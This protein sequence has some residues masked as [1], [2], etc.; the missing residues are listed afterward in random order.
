M[1]YFLSTFDVTVWLED[2]VML[3]VLGVLVDGFPLIKMY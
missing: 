3:L 1:I 2:Y